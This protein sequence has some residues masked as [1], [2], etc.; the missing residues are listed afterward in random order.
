MIVNLKNCLSGG[1]TRVRKSCNRLKVAVTHL[2]R[3]GES[4]SLAS[5]TVTLSE[6]SVCGFCPTRAQH[7]FAVSIRSVYSNTET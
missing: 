5:Y 2:A 7:V 3:E 1:K 4:W 6:W